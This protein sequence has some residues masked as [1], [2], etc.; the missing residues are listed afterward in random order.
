MK[1]ASQ[2]E[3]VLPASVLE[4]AAQSRDSADGQTFA[5]LAQ[6]LSEPTAVNW[7]THCAGQTGDPVLDGVPFT[8]ISQAQID[9]LR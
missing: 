7:E 5:A 1:V 8:E 3:G 2:G 9:P 6:A 4:N